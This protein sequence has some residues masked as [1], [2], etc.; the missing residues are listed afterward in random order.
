MPGSRDD[1]IERLCTEHLTLAHWVAHKVAN[2]SGNVIEF[3]DMTSA[4]MEGLVKAARGFDPDRGVKFSSYAV[5]VIWGAVVDEIRR[6]LGQRKQGQPDPVRTRLTPFANVE[7]LTVTTSPSAED[8][9]LACSDFGELVD[10][11]GFNTRDRAILEAASVYGGQKRL[12]Q[13]T[14]VTEAA[15]SWAVTKLRWR[16]EETGAAAVIRE[17]LTA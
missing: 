9:A 11:F 13:Q 16:L 14:G 7:E 12:A 15:I 5:P 2:Q 10:S 3:E 17:T 4:A 1:D 6:Q 8:E